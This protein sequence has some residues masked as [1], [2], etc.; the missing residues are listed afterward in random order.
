MRI[1]MFSTKNYEPTLLDEL[2][3]GHGHDLVYF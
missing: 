1:A 3:A 2:N